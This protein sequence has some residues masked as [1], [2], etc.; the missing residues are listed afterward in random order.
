MCVALVTDWFCF[1]AS[2]G[3]VVISAA[4]AESVAE[5]ECVQWLRWE[6][7][8]VRFVCNG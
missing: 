5:R 2:L 8:V 6:G 3:Y 7:V 1:G 4:I